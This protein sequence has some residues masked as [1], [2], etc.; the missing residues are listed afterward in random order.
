M[1]PAESELER[2]ISNAES[3]SLESLQST[4]VTEVEEAAEHVAA[5]APKYGSDFDDANAVD[6]SHKEKRSTSGHY[7]SA[8]ITQAEDE[9]DTS[10]SAHV[11][12]QQQATGRFL[13]LGSAPP[14]PPAASFV[15]AASAAAA[16][17]AAAVAPGT[18]PVD[19]LSPATYI[20]AAAAAD[21]VADA[22]ASSASAVPQIEPGAPKSP[23]SRFAHLKRSLLGQRSMYESD[24][25]ALSIWDVGGNF[26]ACHDLLMTRYV[27]KEE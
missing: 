8:A 5:R 27:T 16:A 26:S 18:A 12:S 11:A 7:R 17:A 14:S 23:T 25:V 9:N 21:P 4:V 6:L 13:T 1:D 20:P 22:A 15:P 10:Q 24:K 2:A 3:E 19:V